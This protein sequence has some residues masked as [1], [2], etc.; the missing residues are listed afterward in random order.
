M[1]EVS[2][3]LDRTAMAT[4]RL[5]RTAMALSDAEMRDP[6]LLPGWTRATC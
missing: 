4:E 1:N 5:L 3:S 6:S 2:H